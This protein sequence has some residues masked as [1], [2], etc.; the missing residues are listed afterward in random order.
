M[1]DDLSSDRGK[2][3]SLEEA[4]RTNAEWRAE[5][6]LSRSSMD[7]DLSTA[8]TSLLGE[9]LIKVRVQEHDIL[10]GDSFT[11]FMDAAL[12]E[13]CATLCLLSD[14]YLNSEW[15]RRESMA[16]MA[17]PK[18]QFIPV[19]MQEGCQPDGLLASRV[20]VDASP[21][22]TPDQL[23]KL[24][25]LIDEVLTNGQPLES[26]P[27]AA[28]QV[29]QSKFISNLPMDE[30]LPFVGRGDEML[31]LDRSLQSG[32]STA[33]ITAAVAGMGGVG[34]SYL[35]RIYAIRRRINYQG[36]WWIRAEE[37]ATLIEDLADLGSALNPELRQVND[38]PAVAKMTLQMLAGAPSGRP[39]LLV[40]D[41]VT[42][43]DALEGWRPAGG[44]H[45][46]I[47]SRWTDW[48][49][50]GV[51]AMR[52]DV[53]GEAEA[54]ALLRNRAP[55]ITEDDAKRIAH[56]LGYLP[57]ALDHAA[58]TIR[59]AG[60]SASE[61]LSDLAQRIAKLPKAVNYPTSVRAAIEANLDQ[62]IAEDPLCEKLLHIA[63]Y[64][65]PD[66][67]PI[68]L[69]DAQADPTLG[70]GEDQIQ[71]GLKGVRDAHPEL[72]DVSDAQII[73]MM[74]EESG[75]GDPVDRKEAFGVLESWSLVRVD[76]DDPAGWT[77]IASPA[78]PGGGA[79]A[80]GRGWAGQNRDCR[81]NICTGY[82]LSGRS[83]GC[84]HMARLVA[85]AI[86]C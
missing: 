29:R 58:A 79:R 66:D 2:I 54:I 20:Y 45:V 68:E 57:L 4:A 67:I 3:I 12:R 51:E 14:N 64:C 16:A 69:W 33:A 75:I 23:V 36:V 35:A 8:L 1:T 63:A 31:A 40:Y 81:H 50:Q 78:C 28:G 48:Q 77:L 15:C 70:M 9:R 39:F 53:L 80:I 44:A 24:A 19:V 56:E 6:F 73:A 82:T 60:L 86:T 7:E 10:T 59:R 27:A 17:V 13:T 74:K 72:A 84:A 71:A 37:Q 22:T 46:L 41:N 30:N 49:A 34:K 18:H 52:L 21:I 43:P 76:R 32:V 65:A 61:Y 5:I 55:R 26:N 42:D 25:A 38:R 47:T 85:P 62:A 83:A 11:Q